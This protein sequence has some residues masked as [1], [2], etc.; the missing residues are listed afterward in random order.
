MNLSGS[1]IQDTY[2]RV[3]HT[4]GTKVYDGAGNTIFGS[5][6]FTS[7]KAVDNANI[8]SDEWGYLAGVKSVD[9]T[10]LSSIDQKL[11]T[12]SDVTF[13]S[14]TSS[15][16]LS[17]NLHVG[18]GAPM[19]VE[20]TQ[21]HGSW[22]GGKNDQYTWGVSGAGVFMFG[23]RS[24]GEFTGVASG[25]YDE[26]DIDVGEVS[27]S[28]TIGGSNLSGTNT[29]DQ[30]LSSYIQTNDNAALGTISVDQ[31]NIGGNSAIS[32]NATYSLMSTA[33]KQTFLSTTGQFEFTDTTPSVGQ[34]TMVHIA[35]DT[36]VDGTITASGN[37][38]CS[39]NL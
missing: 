17:S 8:T 29:G 19:I 13:R 23:I 24:N 7:L 31:I 36:N 1:Y 21:W 39:G 9:W 5:V 30:D 15:V 28:G 6:E 3:L 20:S 35:G 11:G 4:D 10:S 22:L 14:V 37:I 38:S 2:Q 26:P 16:F 33:V 32:S 18:P 25:L 34:T 27:A 12:A